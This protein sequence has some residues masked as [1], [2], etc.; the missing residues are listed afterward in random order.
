VVPGRLLEGGFE[1]QFPHGPE[2]AR[3]L[4]IRWGAAPEARR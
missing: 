3:D 1:F 2:A 4:V